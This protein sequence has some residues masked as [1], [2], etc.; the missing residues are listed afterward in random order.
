MSPVASS[1]HIDQRHACTLQEHIAMAVEDHARWIDQDH[2]SHRRTSAS[3]KRGRQLIVEQD[4]HDLVAGNYRVG[5]GV[6]HGHRRNHAEHPGV[7]AGFP[8]DKTFC[9]SGQG[10]LEGGEGDDVVGDE[11]QRHHEAVVEQRAILQDFYGGARA[12]TGPR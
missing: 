9:V 8:C 3:C 2:R 10:R 11:P 5:P 4:L 1:S 6:A 12:A 7:R